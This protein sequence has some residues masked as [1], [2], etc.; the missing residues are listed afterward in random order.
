M[1]THMPPGPGLTDGLGGDATHPS[2]SWCPRWG[3]HTLCQMRQRHREE[4]L[5][6]VSREPEAPEAS[7]TTQLW[8][9]WGQE[10][11]SGPTRRQLS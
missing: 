9:Q 2:L 4:A 3:S 1:P 11:V 6:P 7:K 10:P 5:Q 8:T